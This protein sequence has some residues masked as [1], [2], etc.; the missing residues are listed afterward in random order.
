[1]KATTRLTGMA[2]L[3]AL[4]LAC[5]L[6]KAPVGPVPPTFDGLSAASSAPFVQHIVPPQ[7]TDPAIDQALDDH[8]AWLD[9]TA[10]SNHKLFLFM[11][12]TAQRP[13]Q[14]QLVPQEAARLGYHVIGLMYPNS[15]R[16]EICGGVPDPATCYENAR[17]EIVDGVDRSPIM[18]VNAA[19]SID[20]RLTKLLQ[21]LAAQYPEE[22]WSRFLAHDKPKWSRIAVSGFSQGGGEAA[23]IAKLRLVARV[24]M[25][26]APTDSVG[27]KAPPW[28]A[29]HMTPSDRYWGLAH[30]RDVFFQPILAGWDS[31]GM[32]AFGEWVAPEASA[33]PYGFTH[34]LVTDLLPRDGSYGGLSPH[35]ST[36]GDR[37]TPLNPDGTCCALRDAWRY[38]LTARAA[39][40][41]SAGEDESSSGGDR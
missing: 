10:R 8:Y 37:L 9:T 7:A 16:L 41:I 25:F 2:A 11:P 1:M 14:I 39:D 22:G 38:L 13:A 28:L 29:T 21:F 26:S 15:V 19:N 12:G 34:M 33:P 31:L 36:A 20:N 35:R 30:D 23:M 6:D 18:N 17:L 24:V 27:T 40:Q 5:N 3:S 4:A 32:A